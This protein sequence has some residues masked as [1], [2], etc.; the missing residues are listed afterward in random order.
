MLF[1][2]AITVR[3]IRNANGSLLKCYSV[4]LTLYS[5]YYLYSEAKDFEAELTSDSDSTYLTGSQSCG[6]EL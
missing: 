2:N 4:I 5:C 1:Y 6:D 3:D